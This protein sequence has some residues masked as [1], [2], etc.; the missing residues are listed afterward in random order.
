MSSKFVDL[1]SSFFLGTRERRGVTHTTSLAFFYYQK[2][3]FI[4]T[5]LKKGEN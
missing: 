2:G 1:V 3:V 4:Y 5:G